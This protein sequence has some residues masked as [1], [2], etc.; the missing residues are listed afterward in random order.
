MGNANRSGVAPS[1][2]YGSWIGRLGPYMTKICSSLGIDFHQNPRKCRASV[3]Q[4]CY[5]RDLRITPLT[6][7]GCLS[8]FTLS[9]LKPFVVSVV[10][11]HGHKLSEIRM[12]L[13]LR[14]HAEVSCF[15]WMTALGS[16]LWFWDGLNA[17]E[18]TSLL[19]TCL[20]KNSETPLDWK[21]PQVDLWW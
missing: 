17:F 15:C 9:D 7:A 1:W 21:E 16:C 19:Q 20:Q 11:Q 4:G 10:W 13:E 5:A 14:F 6:K 8:R 2:A 3:C 18:G 12:S